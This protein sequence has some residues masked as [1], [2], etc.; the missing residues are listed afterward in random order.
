MFW[1]LNVYIYLLMFC[2]QKNE[3]LNIHFVVYIYNQNVQHP[4][5]V[6]SSFCGNPSAS[7]KCIIVYHVPV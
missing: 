2:V 6:G 7:N 5:N 3:K 4:I 1:V